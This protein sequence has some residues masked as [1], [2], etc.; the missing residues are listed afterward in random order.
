MLISKQQQLE[1]E[2]TGR[3]LVSTDLWTNTL[4]W[5][6]EPET[7]THHF[8][9]GRYGSH[10]IRGVSLRDPRASAHWDG[11]KFNNNIS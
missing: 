1:L 7:Q 6:Y 11:Y 9:G 10:S 2:A 8:S 5:K 4:S 3:F